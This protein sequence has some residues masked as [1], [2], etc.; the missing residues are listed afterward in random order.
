M[1]ED[2]KSGIKIAENPREALISSTIANTEKQILSA[3][4]EL[5]INKVVL[6]Y[7]KEQK[8]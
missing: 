8:V 7:L 5:E 6:K 3:E 1:I 2:K 4:L